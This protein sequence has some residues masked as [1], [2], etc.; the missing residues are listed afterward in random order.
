[1][2]EEFIP[3]HRVLLVSIRETIKSLSV[4]DATRYAW[5]VDLHRAENVNWFWA[6][7][8]ESLRAFSC[9]TGGWMLRPVNQLER[10][11][12]A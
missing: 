10:I 7:I 3:S 2:S 4:Y 11:F 8:R 6:A 1:M 5:P 12:R 9:H